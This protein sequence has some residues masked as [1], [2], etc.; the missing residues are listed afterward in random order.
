MMHPASTRLPILLTS[1]VIAHDT[2]VKLTDTTQRL[3][4]ALES[5][6]KWLEICPDFRLI[7][8]DGSDFDFTPVVAQRFPAANIECL[9]FENN[10]SLVKS[11]GRGY[12][13]GEIVAHAVAHS[14]YIRDAGAFTKCTSKLW[15]HN[16]LHYLQDWNG[17]LLLQGIFLNPISP[18]RETTLSY[19][20]TRFYISSVA[21]YRKYFQSAH[22]KVN[23]ATGHGLENCFLDI[24]LES[25]MTDAL[26]TRAPVICGVGGAIGKYYKSSWRRRLKEDLRVFMARRNKNFSALFIHSG[27]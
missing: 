7:L 13:E 24:F 11:L 20:D 4:H 8:C 14:K 5:V 25:R 1:S 3:E 22:L 15:V 2:N 16:Y 26:I 6:E 9:H 18:F 23:P 27:K 17:K 12:G 10:Q 21:L 19:I